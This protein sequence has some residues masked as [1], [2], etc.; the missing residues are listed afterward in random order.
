[1]LDV[2]IDLETMGTRPDAAIVAIGAVEFEAWPLPQIGRSLY[3]PVQLASSV[4]A[5][6]TMDP[7]TVLWWLQ[8]D[9]AARRELCSPAAVTLRE[10]LHRL[11]DW[12]TR[13][14]PAARLRVWG[15]GAAFDNVVLR[16]AYQRL[17]MDAPWQWPDDRCFRTLR[18]MVPLVP[19][20][21]R[22]GTAHHALDD[23]RHQARHAVAM[24]RALHAMG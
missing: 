11:A 19:A 21:E 3:L 20:P 16:G 15:N 6:G 12:M 7:A 18:K 17:G 24:L 2:M 10:A 9:D 13:H 22:E 8:Q 1:M 14:R 23:A 5:G 4:A